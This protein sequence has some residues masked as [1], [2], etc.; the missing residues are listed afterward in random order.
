MLTVL[1]CKLFSINNCEISD[2]TVNEETNKLNS[3]S[4]WDIIYSYHIQYR[5]KKLMGALLAVLKASNK[6]LAVFLIFCW[7]DELVLLSK[8]AIVFEVHSEKIH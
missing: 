8:V 2:E 5:R 1:Y 4:S 6:S 3:G 7:R